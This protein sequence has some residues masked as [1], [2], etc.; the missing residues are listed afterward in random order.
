MTTNAARRANRNGA[1]LLI[2]AVIC[3]LVLGLMGLA[4]SA[5]AGSFTSTSEMVSGDRAAAAFVRLALDEAQERIEEEA[6]TFGTPWY[7]VLR[8]PRLR[9][10]KF[11]AAEDTVSVA[12]TKRLAAEEGQAGAQISVTATFFQQNAFGVRSEGKLWGG[13]QSYGTIAL[14]ATVKLEAPRSGIFTVGRKA[15]A[16]RLIGYRATLPE[17]AAPFDQSPLWIKDPDFLRTQAAAVEQ[18]VLSL[19]PGV[20]QQS[21]PRPED[22]VKGLLYGRLGLKE[23]TSAGLAFAAGGND[24]AGA[25]NAL[26]SFW[27]GFTKDYRFLQDAFAKRTMTQLYWPQMSEDSFKGDTLGRAGRA[28]KDGAALAAHLGA[29]GGTV[30]LD[31]TYYVAEPITIDWTYAGRGC[32]VSPRTITVARATRLD[33]KSADTLTLVSTEGSIDVSQATETIEAALFATQGTVLGLSGK[34]VK[35]LLAAA[36]LASGFEAGAGTRIELDGALTRHQPG[37]MMTSPDSL[38]VEFDDVPLAQM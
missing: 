4:G 31:G 12:R 13:D 33:P 19:C 27:N 16:K 35:G 7:T 26:Q 25:A 11:E 20:T 21:L 8:K 32:I 36:H 10:S 37:V 1:A 30:V 6:R 34:H 23:A 3:V 18:Q 5:G 22:F 24:C 2:L 14:E 28:F 17:P 29:G 38:Q 9:G 15:Q